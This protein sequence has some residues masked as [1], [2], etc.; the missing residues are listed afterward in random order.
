MKE[1]VQHGDISI[2]MEYISST[3][4]DTV[5]TLVLIHALGLDMNSWDLSIPYLQNN[6]HILRYDL[7]GHGETHF[8]PGLRTKKILALLRDDLAFLLKELNIHSYHII[9][10]GL[11]GFP[12][13]QLASEH[14]PGLKTLTLMSVPLHYPKALG[15]K[16]I[17][18]R[19]NATKGSDTMAQ[20][21][22]RV[23]NNAFFP[24]TKEKTAILL[25]AYQKVKASVYFEIFHLDSLKQVLGQLQQ[26]DV[27]ILLLSG[28][29]DNMF[30]PV[31]SDASLH[32]NKNARHII[33]PQASFML[34]MDQPEMMSECIHQF[35]GH[36]R[37]HLMYYG[38]QDASYQ[39]N[40]THEL[41]KEIKRILSDGNNEIAPANHLR[42]DVM[43]GFAVY[44]NGKRLLS[45]WGKRKAK[46]ILLYL[47][48]Q[49]SATREEVCDVLWPD[50]HLKDARNRLRVSLHHL[51]KLVR[52]SYQGEEFS[53]LTTEREHLFLQANVESDIEAYMRAIKNAHTLENR[54]E[55]IAAYQ[56][57]LRGKSEN[58]I[59]GFFEE[60]FLNIR[61]WIE[62]EW[63]EM[64]VFL[65][66]HFEQTR[67][68]QL[69]IYY[70]EMILP[71]YGNPFELEGRI[72][73]LKKSIIASE[74]K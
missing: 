29:E 59:P 26:I 50:V 63:V 11:G 14:A 62:N 52:F 27:P 4:P 45:G 23:M 69:S 12:G 37:H 5:D 70:G 74:E 46:Q 31:L 24:P 3:N 67:E 41:N 7:R 17:E 73:S 51:K 2:Y 1:T 48:F 72:R 58:V 65:V 42:V 40:L 32:F 8:E 68:Y 28:E 49:Q 64:A 25:D 18:G 35:I 30:P 44:V 21:G 66:N 56:H 71:Y 36:Q 34:Q 22:R 15:G 9:G 61:S 53:L 19:K 10:H 6:Y 57:L 54:D 13:V 16:V 38:A 60:W 55:K 47:V 20:L 43:N 39:Y 33:V